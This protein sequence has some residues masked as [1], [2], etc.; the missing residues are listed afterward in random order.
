MSLKRVFVRC[1]TWGIYAK[2]FRSPLLP[3]LVHHIC[4]IDGLLL[5]S[6]DRLP[7]SDGTETHPS[8]RIITK[9][10]IF[11]YYWIQRYFFFQEPVFWF[12]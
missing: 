11:R 2:H 3:H 4:L 7:P 12:S 10:V 9:T 8:F 5:L 6:V 1:V